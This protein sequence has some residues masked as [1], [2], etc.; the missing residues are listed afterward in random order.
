MFE[1]AGGE[2]SLADG[3][4]KGVKIDRGSRWIPAEVGE[5]IDDLI[6]RA[7]PAEKVYGAR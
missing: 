3:W 7:V 1:V 2:I 5:A 4:R 6:Q